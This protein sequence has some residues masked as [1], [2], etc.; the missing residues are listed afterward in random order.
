MGGWQQ[1]TSESSLWDLSLAKLFTSLF[2][3]RKIHKTYLG[4]SVGEFEKKSGTFNDYLYYYEGKKEV[5][6]KAI[7][8]FKVL[9]SN[10]NYTLLKL[11]PETGRKHQIRKQLY[12]HGYP[13]L[14][15]T[16]YRISDNKFRKNNNL[17][18][19]AYKINFSINNVKYKFVAKPSDDFNI[20][21]KEKHLKIY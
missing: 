8:H 15:D 12:L 21:L 4:I 2:R 13:I 3:I 10:N 16:K 19:H 18:L 7:T 14:G 5:K 1:R 11:N 17:M 20:V 9:D 6:T